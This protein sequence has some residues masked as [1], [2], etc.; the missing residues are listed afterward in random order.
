MDAGTG[1]VLVVEDDA[2][3]REVIQEFLETEGYHVS[4]A[5]N[6]KEALEYLN[7]KTVIPK[8]ILLDLFMPVMD[9]KEF[10]QNFKKSHSELSSSVPVIVLSAAPPA[11]EQVREV[12]ELSTGFI[13]KPIDLENFID[14]VRQYCPT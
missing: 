5:T 2:D 3:I 12:K 11:G 1:V 13:K 10:L 7:K 4:T 14:T 6:G 9:G 8:L